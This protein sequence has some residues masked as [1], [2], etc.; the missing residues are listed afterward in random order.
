MSYLFYSKTGD[1]RKM[2]DIGAFCETYGN[3]IRNRILEYLLENQDLDF[4]IGD[5]AKE[6]KIS[7]PKAYEIIREFE[8]KKYV[9]KSRMI[10]KTQL[11]LLNKESKRVKLF[12]RDFKECLKIVVKEYEEILP[13]AEKEILAHVYLG[14]TDVVQKLLEAI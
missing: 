6:L 13:S 4:A 2:K 1:V 3:T 14:K 8:K 12:L 9:K 10:G 11:Y 7:R 5:M